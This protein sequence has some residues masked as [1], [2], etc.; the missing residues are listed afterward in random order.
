MRT[1]AGTEVAAHERVATALMAALE[2]GDTDAL[3]ALYAPDV[4]VWHN[5]DRIEQ[6]GAES[7]R[8]L[9][10]MSRRVQGMRYENV[11]RVLVEDGFVQQHLMS[12]IDPAFTAPC[13][14][15]VWCRDG[16]IT[17]IEEYLD[18]ADV[19]VVRAMAAEHLRQKTSQKT[20]QSLN[21]AAEPEG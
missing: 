20:S 7:V 9:A 16:R 21:T 1:G 17:R 12:A 19:A 4:A 6:T 18:S 8:T 11:R 2:A 14:L 15:R 10:W 13:M 3:A 5:Y